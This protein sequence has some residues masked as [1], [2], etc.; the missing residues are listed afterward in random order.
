M[1]ATAKTSPESYRGGKIL[2]ARPISLRHLSYGAFLAIFRFW[3]NRRQIMK[4]QEKWLKQKK[5]G[6]SG[7]AK[8]AL[9]TEVGGSGVSL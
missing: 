3:P 5:M 2:L 4:K 6:D 7:V 9:G 1:R 8:V